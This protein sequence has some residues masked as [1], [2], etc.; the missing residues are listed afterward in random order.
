MSGRTSTSSKKTKSHEGVMIDKKRVDK[1]KKEMAKAHKV[2][3]G[4]EALVFGD[5]DAHS[6][7][8]EEEE[9]VGDDVVDKDDDDVANDDDDDDEG[10]AAQRFI[11]GDKLTREQREDIASLIAVGL[12]RTTIAACYVKADKKEIKPNAWNN[13]SVATADGF[14]KSRFLGELRSDFE[15]LPE[16]VKNGVR[17]LLYQHGQSPAEQ[18]IAF[19]TRTRGGEISINVNDVD[20]LATD[21][22]S[23]GVGPGAL[24]FTTP[25]KT[26]LAVYSKKQQA[27]PSAIT[28]DTEVTESASIAEE[29]RAH[30][31]HAHATNAHA[32]VA[33]TPAPAQ[34]QK[35]KA[36][37]IATAVPPQQP[38]EFAHLNVRT[39]GFVA[40]APAKSV[41]YYEK[42]SSE[43]QPN[44]ECDGS[45]SS[46]SWNA[47][48]RFSVV[49]RDE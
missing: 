2:L 19:N 43:W 10:D 6:G 8:E 27:P 45:V 30:E 32:K 4:V 38:S 33:A 9:E 40:E 48:D 28:A 47:D 12:S 26:P 21:M 11:I 14:S 37:E 16:R 13:L 42:K 20:V 1:I 46:Y 35:R 3:K 49:F 41:S 44:V 15:S 18:S 25:A 7:E 34:A 17:R 36:S 31:T 29:P 39:G 23:S 5:A 22:K 24:V